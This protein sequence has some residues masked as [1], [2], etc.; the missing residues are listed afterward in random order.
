MSGVVVSVQICPGQREPM[1]VVPE[2]QLDPGGI[3]GD[4]HFAPGSARQLLMIEAETLARFGLEPGQVKENVTTSGVDLM[5]L[6]PGTRLALGAAEVE[7]ADECHPCSRMDEIRSG[8]MLEL[9][10][11][12]GMLA[13]VVRPG[14]VRPGDPVR[15]LERA[16]PE[17]VG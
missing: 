13:K 11:S 14:R 10:G 8:L 6:A 9:E 4:R 3:R 12:R 7:L 16:E 15:V 5:S 1:R 17:V 2:A